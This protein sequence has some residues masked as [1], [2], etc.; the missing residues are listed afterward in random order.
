MPI[1]ECNA[2]GVTTGEEG[3]V[4]IIYGCEECLNDDGSFKAPAIRRGQPV[5]EKPLTEEERIAQVHQVA[6]E[7]RRRKSRRRI[8]A[9][10][11][12]RNPQPN[13][14][15]SVFAGKNPPSSPGK[16]HRAHS[17]RRS[18]RSER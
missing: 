2:C 17:D 7:R 3:P 10:R 18:H 1:A 6:K 15:A 12:E 13:K 9:A 8:E 16:V 11:P 14:P 5:E 4:I